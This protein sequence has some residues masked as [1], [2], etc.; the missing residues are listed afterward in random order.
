MHN[1]RYCISDFSIWWNITYWSVLRRKISLS[2]KGNQEREFMMTFRNYMTDQ[3]T[4]TVSE[5][6]QLPS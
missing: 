1:R 3:K 4:S 6:E 2:I 5:N